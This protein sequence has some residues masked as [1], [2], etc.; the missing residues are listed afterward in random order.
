M[1]VAA[2]PSNSI[3]TLL[4]IIALVFLLVAVVF[5]ALQA[6]ARYGWSVPFG[7]KY[8]KT[9]KDHDKAMSDLDRGIKEAENALET[10]SLNTTNT[11][12]NQAGGE[13]PGQ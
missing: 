1:Q 2:Q 9:L 12:Q 11:S 13:L 10:V 3:Y 5:V 6:D 7:E 4:T 8:E